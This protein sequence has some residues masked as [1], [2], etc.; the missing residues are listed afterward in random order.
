MNMVE[1]SCCGNWIPNTKKHNTEWG[2][3]NEPPENTDYWTMLNAKRL[4]GI[5]RIPEGRRC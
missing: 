4:P 2:K 1:C 3:G 5:F